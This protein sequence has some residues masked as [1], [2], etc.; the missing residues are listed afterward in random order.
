MHA[1]K[2]PPRR[3]AALDALLR[4]VGAKVLWRTRV[5]GQVVGSQDIDEAL[6]IWY[7]NPQAF[8]NLMSAPGSAENMRLRS[9]A[10]QHADLHRCEAY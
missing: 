4:Q 3:P 7:P 1:S 9:L 2:S 8:L 6:G 10:V 5:F